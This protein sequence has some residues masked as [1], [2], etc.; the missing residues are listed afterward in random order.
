MSTSHK[1]DTSCG[2]SSEMNGFFIL[3][4]SCLIPSYLACMKSNQEILAMTTA[5]GIDKIKPTDTKSVQSISRMMNTM[6]A[7]DSMFSFNCPDCCQKSKGKTTHELAL[8]TDECDKL[9]KKVAEMKKE[10]ETMKLNNNTHFPMDIDENNQNN[11]VT[12]QELQKILKQFELA[13]ESKL[14][15]FANGC[16]QTPSNKRK[17]LIKDQI[18]FAATPKNTHIDLTTNIKQRELLKPP[19]TDID[20]RSVYHIMVSEFGSEMTPENLSDYIL[21]NT[22]IKLSDLFKVEVMNSESLSVNN[23]AFKISTFSKEIKDIIMDENL[24]APDYKAIDHIP[25]EKSTRKLTE[26]FNMTPSSSR[27]MKPKRHTRNDTYNRFDRNK[28]AKPNTP[29]RKRIQFDSPISKRS[30]AKQY[31]YTYAKGNPNTFFW[32][33][34]YQFPTQQYV[35]AMVP[36]QQQYLQQ[37]TH[38]QNLTYPMNQTQQQQQQQQHNQHQ[39]KM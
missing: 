7:E 25:R 22:N 8:A 29:A 35:Y 11:P 16:D 21:A 19:K 4:R 34:P 33:N 24:W 18:I 3:C 13:I 38:S 17:R 23:I 36:N 20:N 27:K 1:C 37:Q 26:N 39:Q 14:V 9:R 10:L 12:Q 30:N 32:Q 31:N 28:Y 2:G 5:M 6:F 15:T